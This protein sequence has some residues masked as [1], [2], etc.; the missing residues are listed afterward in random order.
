[1][2]GSDLQR[3]LEITSG[4]ECA[5]VG[6]PERRI[7][8]DPSEGCVCLRHQVQLL[9]VFGQTRLGVRQRTSAPDLCVMCGAQAEREVRHVPQITG[10]VR[11]VAGPRVLAGYYSVWCTSCHVK[12]LMFGY[13]PWDYNKVK[14]TSINSIRLSRDLPPV[15]T[16]T[17]YDHFV[18]DDVLDHKTDASAYVRWFK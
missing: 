9:E 15:I 7:A 1:M 2:S 11:E 16:G 10:L 13:D 18:V 3:F 14:W 6:C 17:R 12:H 5:V 4:S 8:A